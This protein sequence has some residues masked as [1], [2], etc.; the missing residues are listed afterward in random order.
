MSG[1][2]CYYNKYDEDTRNEADIACKD[3]TYEGVSESTMEI[4]NSLGG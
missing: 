2:D 3:N 1:F 4:I